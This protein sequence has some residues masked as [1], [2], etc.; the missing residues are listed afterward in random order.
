MTIHWT[1]DV[2][3]DTQIWVQELFRKITAP[4]EDLLAILLFWRDAKLTHVEALDDSHFVSDTAKTELYERDIP[5]MLRE[6]M[7]DVI[8]LATHARWRTETEHG[9]DVLVTVVGTDFVRMTRSVVERRPAAPPVLRDWKP[10]PDSP[11]LTVKS[12]INDALLA[13]MVDVHRP[14]GLARLFRRQ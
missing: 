14:R 1:G 7:P 5:R 13:A 10:F 2:M 8:S 11:D 3:K 12:W 9:E 6:R 4:D